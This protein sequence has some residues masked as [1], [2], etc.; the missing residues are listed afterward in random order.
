MKKLGELQDKAFSNSIEYQVKQMKSLQKEQEKVISNIK[1][2]TNEYLSQAQ[3]LSNLQS[4]H[5]DAKV[6]QMERQKA[7]DIESTKSWGW[8]DE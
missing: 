6:I 3:T 5:N 7:A 8:T 4:S 1:Q 2:A